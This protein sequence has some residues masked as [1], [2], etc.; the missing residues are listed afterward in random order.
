MT[1]KLRS[2]LSA[3]VRGRRL[4][5]EMEE[6]WRFHLAERVEALMAS[7]V[8]RHEAEQVRV[9]SSA[10]RCDGKEGREARGLRLIDELR[11]DVQYA[12]RQMGRTRAATLVIMATLALAIGANTAIFTLFDAVMLKALPVPHPEELKQLV[13][14]ARRFG[15]HTTY[16]GSARSNAAGE[17][18]AT[19]FSH[20]VIANLRDHATTFSDVFCFDHPQQ[21]SVVH[22][23]TAQLVDGQFVSGNY[24][25]GLRVYAIVGR[26]LVED[27]DK[28][29]AQPVAVISHQFW[30]RAFAESPDVI[31][32]RIL[33]NGAPVAIAGVMPP[34]FFGVLPGSRLDIVLALAVQSVLDASTPPDAL[35]RADRWGLQVMARMKPGE[36]AARA[37]AESEA[38]V[39]QAIVAYA[40]AKHTIYR[41][42]V[43]DPGY[44]GLADLRREYS[45]PLGILMGMVGPFC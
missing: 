19:S 27:D 4:D 43:L 14:V 29:G 30:R 42:I 1:T 37:Q 3:L 16:N 40:P 9:W 44:R 32:R 11:S 5:R 13:W 39:R 23:G 2:F 12:L 22:D 20:P 35:M 36:S 25:R 28:P 6:E 41:R 7:G 33:V 10:I 8:S 15:F 34:S 31:S 26:T 45:S 18:V 24:F 21:L 17:R 38:L